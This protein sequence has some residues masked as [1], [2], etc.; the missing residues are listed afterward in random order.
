MKGSQMVT[1]VTEISTP[2]T[3]ADPPAEFEQKAAKV[4]SELHQ[5]VPQMNQQADEIEQIGAAAQVAKER[6][7]QESD[8][9]LGYRNEAQAAKDLAQAAKAT[10]VENAGQSIA[11]KEL[12]E[13]AAESAGQS[14]VQANA[15]LAAAEQAIAMAAAYTAV[16]TTFKAWQI[17]VTQPHL[18]FMVWSPVLN[19]YVRA[20]WHQP[21]Q[22]FFSYDN[23]SSIPGALPVRA[24]AVWQQADFPD[25]VARLG[26]S[27][28]GTFALVEARG[29]GVRVLDNGRG[30]DAGRVLRSLQID[31]MQ[32]I[33]G[34]LHDYAPRSGFSTNGAFTY[35]T[36]GSN[37]RQVGV[38]TGVMSGNVTV[39]DS[40]RV[41]RTASET[42]MRNIAFPLWMTF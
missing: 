3:P 30:V 1:H 20:P 28:V 18:R 36:G 21:C 32:Q 4:W 27:G 34:E 11:A 40:G 33:Y 13:S 25:V 10:A 35:A 42:R 6:A 7:I 38:G 31:A 23:P 8:A 12:S 19:K 41:T 39:F 16:P 5:A 22:L 26:L 14:A 2:P 17:V 24:D 9:A 29:E 15:T 37:D